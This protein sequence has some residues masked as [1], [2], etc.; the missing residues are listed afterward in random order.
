MFEQAEREA[1]RLREEL[2]ESQDGLRRRSFKG[3]DGARLVEVTVAGDLR[4]RRVTLA[5]QAL[6]SEPEA[7]AA[8]I[9]EATNAGLEMA[10]S[11]QQEKLAAGAARL[12]GVSALPSGGDQ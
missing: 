6:E 5:D 9:T 8:A 4:V 7:L 3:R 10:R 12:L 11:A 1:T 2:A